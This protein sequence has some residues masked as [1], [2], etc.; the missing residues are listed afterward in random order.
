V[1]HAAIAAGHDHSVEADLQPFFYLPF[2]HSEELPDQELS[3]S[4][5]RRLGEP[6]LSHAMHHR[7][8]VK[9]FGRFPHRNPILDRTMRPEEQ[10][11]LDEGG[12]RG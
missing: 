10:G 4:L 6:T 5:C 1:A 11:Y 7:D 12:Y 2:G 8:I 9:R 3:V